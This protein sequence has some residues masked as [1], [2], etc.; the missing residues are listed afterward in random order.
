MDG[1]KKKLGEE[2]LGKK[3]V[4][5]DILE[6]SLLSGGAIKNRHVGIKTVDSEDHSL[7]L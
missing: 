7:D 5:R 4:T 3:Y 2:F 6:F 1:T